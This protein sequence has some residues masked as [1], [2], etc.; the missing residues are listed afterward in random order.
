[1]IGQILIVK[2][3]LY[4]R[5]IIKEVSLLA[6]FTV[7]LIQHMQ[8]GYTALPLKPSGQLY[9]LF[10][11]SKEISQIYVL[12]LTLCLPVSETYPMDEFPTLLKKGQMSSFSFLLLYL[13]IYHH[14]QLFCIL[15]SIW[16]DKSSY[17][18]FPHVLHVL[19]A[20]SAALV[21]VRPPSFTCLTSSFSHH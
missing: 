5:V 18:F 7:K 9:I 21:T 4:S 3:Y 20:S 15:F 17:L 10:C 1:M 8:L 2:D 12:R 14:V 16:Q 19:P 11:G 13:P 6:F